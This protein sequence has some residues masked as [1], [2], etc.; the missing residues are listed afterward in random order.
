MLFITHILIS[1]IHESES[2]YWTFYYQHPRLKSNNCLDFTQLSG[3]FIIIPNCDPSSIHLADFSLWI[4]RC[5][6]NFKVKMW[7]WIL[8]YLI[9]Q[10]I[11]GVNLISYC[12]VKRRLWNISICV[13]NIFNRK[14]CLQMDPI[15]CQYPLNL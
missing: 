10:G 7:R 15:S 6:F 11:G 1:L 8:I 4:I 12:K 2:D 5:N 13:L 3:L 14:S 9:I